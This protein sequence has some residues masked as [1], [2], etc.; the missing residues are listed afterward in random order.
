MM[1]LQLVRKDQ[2]EKL[3]ILGYNQPCSRYWQGNGIMFALPPTDHNYKPNQETVIGYPFLEDRASA[4]ETA[5]AVKWLRDN[6]KAYISMRANTVAN[7]GHPDGTPDGQWHASAW[8]DDVIY[9]ASK[10]TYEEAESCVLNMV[11]D[12]LIQASSTAD[13]HKLEYEGDAPHKCPFCQKEF[14]DSG[15]RDEHQK[16]CIDQPF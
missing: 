15:K 3:K 12:K 10:S 14:D 8:I 2:A 1:E 16:F 9:I 6:K 4:P 11:L 13:I 5:L 7:G